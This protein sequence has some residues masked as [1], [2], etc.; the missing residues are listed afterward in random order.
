MPEFTYRAYAP[1]GTLEEKTVKQETAAGLHENL[2]GRGYRVV[3]LRRSHAKPGGLAGQLPSLFRVK[4]QDLI[5]FSRQLATFLSVGVPIVDGIN[6][7]KEQ[8][9]SPVLR[10]ALE[11]IVEDLDLGE[12]F[13]QALSHHPRIFDRLYIDMVRAAEMSGDL[14]SVLQRMAIYL[15]RQESAVKKLRSAM[16]YPTVIFTLAIV[17]SIVLIV[18]VLPNF[19]SIFKEFHAELPLPTR[20]MLAIGTFARDYE[21][22]I[23]G[24]IAILVGGGVLFFRSKPGK[25]LRD[26]MVL[27]LWVIGPIVRFAII[28]RFT[29]TLAAMLKAGIPIGQT[30]DVA[31][32][33]TSNHR[34]V[35]R[36]EKVRDRMI[37]GEGF[38]APLQ[39]TGLFPNMVTQM[40]RVGEETGTLASYLDSVADMLTEEIEYKVK[41]M[42]SLVEPLMVIGVGVIVGFIGISVITPMYGLLKAIR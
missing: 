19:I 7:I 1:S 26:N 33:S 37:T 39:A 28:E 23:L 13:S 38:S 22:P 5:L 36:L 27:R 24:T 3:S 25:I 11:D 41:N 18:F 21:F 14:E 32:L 31:I 40:I 34:F 12:S 2:V 9:G 29:R 4:A 17:V 42:I 30:F 6:L 20:I 10:A 8:S 15:T 35:T 16:I